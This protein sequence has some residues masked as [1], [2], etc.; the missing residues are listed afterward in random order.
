MEGTVHLSIYYAVQAILYNCTV[1]AMGASCN[2]LLVAIKQAQL[3][4]QDGQPDVTTIGKV[5]VVAN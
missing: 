1:C 3:N 4:V 5:N 2:K